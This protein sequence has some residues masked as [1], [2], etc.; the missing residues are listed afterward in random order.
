MS[1]SEAVQRTDPDG[2]PKPS[3][4]QP[5]DLAI[6]TVDEHGAIV[7]TDDLV[8]VVQLGVSPLGSGEAGHRLAPETPET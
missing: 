7:E 5:H 2:A 8:R 4:H 1:P 3:W 6:G